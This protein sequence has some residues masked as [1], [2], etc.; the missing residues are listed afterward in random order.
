MI[1]WILWRT[2]QAKTGPG[3]IDQ[4]L[5]NFSPDDLLRQQPHLTQTGIL[6]QS[7][8]NSFPPDWL[9]TIYTLLLT[10]EYLLAPRLTRGVYT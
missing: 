1:L 10:M 3:F 5:L 9:F 6:T 4:L 7:K 8:T 2:T